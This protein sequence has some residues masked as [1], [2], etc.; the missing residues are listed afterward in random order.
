MAIPYGRK[1]LIQWDV[2]EKKPEENQRIVSFI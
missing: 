2:A 1:E